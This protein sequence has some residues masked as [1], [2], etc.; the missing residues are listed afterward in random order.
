VIEPVIFVLVYALGAASGASVGLFV[1]CYL[2]LRE[3]RE[4]RRLFTQ[5]QQNRMKN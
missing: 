3:L 2:V 5:Q 4:L 1:G